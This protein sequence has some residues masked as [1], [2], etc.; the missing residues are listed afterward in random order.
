MAKEQMERIK[1]G[2]FY[3]ENC[4]I[5]IYKNGLNFCEKCRVKLHGKLYLEF[6]K[7]FAREIGLKR[8]L[9]FFE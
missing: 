4:Y 5:D 8:T 1:I 7:N 2:N 9:Y 3:G 6:D